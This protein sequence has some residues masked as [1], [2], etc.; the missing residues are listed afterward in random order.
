MSAS[1]SRIRWGASNTTQVWGS[2]RNSRSRRRRSPPRWGRN[3]SKRKRSAARPL[4]DNSVVTADGPATGN[5]M[6]LYP[7]KNIE[8]FRGTAD[9]IGE[10]LADQVSDVNAVTRV[11]LCV[12]HVIANTAKMWDPVDDNTD[13]ATPFIIDVKAL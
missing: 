13:L 10:D 12:K 7:G 11:A 3:P 1:V 5:A 4:A 8:T 6:V 9:H 2:S